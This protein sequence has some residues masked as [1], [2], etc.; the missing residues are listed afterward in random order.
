MMD[1]MGNPWAPPEH[2]RPQGAPPQAPASPPQGPPPQGGPGPGTGPHAGPGHPGAPHATRP[3]R[4]G[5]PA[6]APD[7]GPPPHPGQPEPD[8]AGIA[9]STRTAAWGAVALLVAVLLVSAPYPWAYA[10]PL[11]SLAALTLGVVA[12]VRGVRAHARGAVVTLTAVLVVASVL[13]TL[14]SVQVFVYAS[15]RE[16][17]QECRA[18]AL[19]VQAERVCDARLVE[20]V[21][22]TTRSYLPTMPTDG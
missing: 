19:T 15:A 12:V 13:W 1:A 7:G 20:D 3:P 14:M 18:R 9:R 16:T 17:H 5:T 21:E 22:R 8:A 11:A 2:P 4:T 6:G 10:T